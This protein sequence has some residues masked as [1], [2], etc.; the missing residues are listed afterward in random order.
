MKPAVIS[1]IVVYLKDRNNELAT[2]SKNRNIEICT[3]E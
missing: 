2:N 3:K 1:E